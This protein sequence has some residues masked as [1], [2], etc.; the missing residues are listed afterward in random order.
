MVV[1]QTEKRATICDALH[2][3][4]RYMLHDVVV[5]IILVE[6]D[7]GHARLIE[8]N[9]R[10]AEVPYELLVFHDGEEALTDRPVL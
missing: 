9:M 8:R 6:D 1:V 2:A 5:T 7:A 3:R 4:G 10:R